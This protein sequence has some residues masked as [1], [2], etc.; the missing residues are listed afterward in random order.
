MKFVGNAHAMQ[1]RETYNVVMREQVL[2]LIIF[3]SLLV[4]GVGSK[5]L[6]WFYILLPL[7]VHKNYFVCV[8]C[9]LVKI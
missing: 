2:I 3:V 7:N 9:Q 8:L 4:E 6:W 5:S 1:Q